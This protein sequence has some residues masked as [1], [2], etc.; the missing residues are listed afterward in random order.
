MQ[1][2]IGKHRE[3]VFTFKGKRVEQVSTAAWYKALR[4]AGIDNFRWHDLR[5]GRAS[6][7]VQE[8]TPLNV[9]KNSAAGPATRWCNGMP[10]WLLITS[11]RGPN[12]SQIAA[13][14]RHNSLGA[15]DGPTACTMQVV[16]LSRYFGG[17]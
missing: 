16:D 9:C 5:H 1:K 14:I 4:R 6:W 11:P 13:Q 8:G 3:I 2:Q 10:I 12:V 15:P 17:P 7:H